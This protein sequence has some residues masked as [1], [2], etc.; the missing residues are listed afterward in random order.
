MFAAYAPDTLYAKNTGAPGLFEIHI[1]DDG[2]VGQAGVGMAELNGD[3]ILEIIVST[4][5]SRLRL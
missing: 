1:V 4:Y 3:G 5:E 2:N